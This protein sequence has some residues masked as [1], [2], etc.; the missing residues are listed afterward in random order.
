MSEQRHEKQ[1]VPDRVVRFSLLALVSVLGGVV[2]LA[3]GMGWLALWGT[4]H[5]PCRTGLFPSAYGLTPQQ[6]AIPSRT[7]YTYAGYL[8][9]DN[10]GP[11]VIVPPP[12]GAD[13]GGM[14][15]E[16]AILV[17]HGYRVLTYDSRQCAGMSAHSLGPWEAQDIVDALNFLQVRD[18]VDTLSVGVLGFSQA[19]ASGLIAAAQDARIQA[20]VAEGGYLDF[21]A[22][23]IGSDETPNLA[24]RLFRVGAWLAYR[25]A[26]GMNLPTLDLEPLLSAIA[27]RR[28]LLVY[29]EHEPTLAAAHWAAE[30]H[31][32]ISLWL[33]PEASHGTYLSAA[34]AEA[35][36]S[37]VI[38]FFDSTLARP[39]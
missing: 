2:L 30:S 26:T 1:T 25:A 36:A 29:G 15:H 31:P 22:Q 27:P 20:V 37:N 38:G 35:F 14:L 3:G 39:N 16:V 32:H 23:T 17:A 9:G 10:G 13:R 5:P 24:I 7:G 21:V 11:T 33:V 28:V 34:G 19:G 6:V 4:T 8:F 12:Y 18:G